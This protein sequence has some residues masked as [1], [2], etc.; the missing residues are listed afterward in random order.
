MAGW[1]LSFAVRSVK[2]LVGLRKSLRPFA[3]S[4]RFSLPPES[5]FLV[6]DFRKGLTLATFF[7]ESWVI[8]RVIGHTNMI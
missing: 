7:I 1:P 4:F 5:A 6:T 3:R 8:A 2:M